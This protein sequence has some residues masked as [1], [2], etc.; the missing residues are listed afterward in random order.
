MRR[1]VLLEEPPRRSPSSIQALS[2]VTDQVW[3]PPGPT[4]SFT[5]ALSEN[6]GR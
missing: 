1:V 6:D 2:A 3:L 4:F 5:V